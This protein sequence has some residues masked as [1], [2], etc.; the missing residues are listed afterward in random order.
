MARAFWLPSVL[1]LCACTS[2]PAVPDWQ[3]QSQSA[4]ENF[5]QRYLEGDSSG[6]ARAFARAKAALASTGKPE[7][8][9]KAELVR[10]ALGVAALDFDACS[11]YDA[12]SADA[13]ADDRVYGDFIS[14]RWKGLDASRLPT[15]YRN[16]AVARDDTERARLLQGIDDPVSRLVAAGALF[17]GAALP[18]EGVATAVD[19]ASAQG[20]RRPLLAYLNVQAKQAHSAGDTAA[21]EAI[22]KRIEI[23]YQ[24]LPDRRNESPH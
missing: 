7:L 11:N 5:R 1:A 2:G 12:Q 20:Y 23:V 14:A 17:R 9:A 6:A 8:V 15:P 21:E 3:A 4:L 18:P 16:I 10:C 13:S 19:T 22:R 24:S